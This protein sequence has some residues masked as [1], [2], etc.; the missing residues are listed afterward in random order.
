[1][2]RDLGVQCMAQCNKHGPLRTA[3]VDPICLPATEATRRALTRIAGRTLFG[4]KERV[5]VL[6]NEELDTS[7]NLDVP[8][9]AAVIST[10]V[11]RQHSERTADERKAFEA[12]LDTDV[13]DDVG[14]VVDMYFRRP[15]SASEGGLVGRT[16]MI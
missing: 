14:R 10:G 1:M 8:A 12:L 7:K 4:T 11:T 13:N 16:R 5:P 2:A 6:G 15:S 9:T 3:A